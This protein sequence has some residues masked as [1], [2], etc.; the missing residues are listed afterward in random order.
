MF[1]IQ[2]VLTFLSLYLLCNYAVHT[3]ISL[4]WTAFN[5]SSF[6]PLVIWCGFMF[7]LLEI[8]WAPWICEFTVFIK[9]QNF[10]SYYVF[11]L[12]LFTPFSL[13]SVDSVQNT[14][15]PDHLIFFHM[16]WCSFYFFIFSHV[17]KTECTFLA[18]DGW[19]PTCSGPF[20]QVWTLK[21]QLTWFFYKCN[22]HWVF[23]EGSQSKQILSFLQAVV[24]FPDTEFSWSLEI[25]KNCIYEKSFGNWY[26]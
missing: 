22:T 24:S 8:W 12:F 16:F 3:C 5:N 9:F 13:F 15:I 18:T 2:S 11:K 23:T 7:L 25:S 14:I 21:C 19:N 6:Q 1:L 10:F 26:R 17:P 20:L 4:T